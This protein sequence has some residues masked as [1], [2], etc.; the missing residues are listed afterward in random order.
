MVER[1]L[2]PWNATGNLLIKISALVSMLAN[3]E[4]LISHKMSQAACSK[5]P[6]SVTSGPAEPQSLL[7]MEAATLVQQLF[8]AD[9]LSPARLLHNFRTLPYKGGKYTVEFVCSSRGWHKLRTGSTM[10]KPETCEER[11][12]L[13]H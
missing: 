6:L 13:F 4:G 11:L 12:C 9:K 8:A 7:P 1:D 3:R 5:Q 10:Q 2:A